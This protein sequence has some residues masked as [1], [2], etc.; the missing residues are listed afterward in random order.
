MILSNEYVDGLKQS[1]VIVV[2]SHCEKIQAQV[3]KKF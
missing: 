1:T 3:I 2:I